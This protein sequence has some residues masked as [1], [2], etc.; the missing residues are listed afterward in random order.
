[1]SHFMDVQGLTVWYMAD[2]SSIQLITEGLG[3]AAGNRDITV[4]PECGNLLPQ[5]C[6]TIALCVLC[7]CWFQVSV[8][9][10]KHG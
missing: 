8:V 2:R 4:A 10:W 5:A 7:L 6:R 3:E 9:N 1:M